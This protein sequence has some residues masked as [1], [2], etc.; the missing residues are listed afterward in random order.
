MDMGTTLV[1]LSLALSAPAALVAALII[2]ARRR[3]CVPIDQPR[4]SFLFE[5][6]AALTLTWLGVAL[7]VSAHLL[8]RTGYVQQD[9][10]A[11]LMWGMFL[12]APLGGIGAWFWGELQH[13]W[14]RNPVLGLLGGL[15]GAVL[16]MIL[17]QVGVGALGSLALGVGLEPVFR[18]V[19]IPLATAPI[20][21]A[22]VGG[23]QLLRGGTRRPPVSTR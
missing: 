21:V 14:S 17:G 3:P 5:G 11:A 7:F 19:E 4:R 20:V 10:G 16:G 6:I 8:G 22:A 15:V 23:Y 13:G 1:L 18:W 2:R 9:Q 12:A